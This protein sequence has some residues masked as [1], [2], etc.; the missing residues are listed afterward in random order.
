[1]MF[2]FHE[3]TDNPIKKILIIFTPKGMGLEEMR[4]KCM[5]HLIKMGNYL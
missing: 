2:P 5:G 3:Q 4:H 1:M